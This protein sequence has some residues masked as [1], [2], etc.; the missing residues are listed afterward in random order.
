MDDQIVQGLNATLTEVMN[1]FR[2][3]F[4]GP[5]MNMPEEHVTL[6]HRADFDA[7]LVTVMGHTYGLRLVFEEEKG[8]GEHPHIAVEVSVNV[9]DD[10]FSLPRFANKMT[11]TYDPT[12]LGRTIENFMTPDD[13]V[14]IRKHGESPFA[15]FFSFQL[16]RDLQ[17]VQKEKTRASTVTGRFVD[18]ILKLR[19][20][21]KTKEIKLLA[22]DRDLSLTIVYLLCLRPFAAAYHES[23]TI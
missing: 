4:V 13:L 10:E 2:D 11:E 21:I 6:R 23:L 15:S 19:Y 18:T 14:H 1:R 8:K 17:L 22:R 7:P 9:Y 16:D 5:G 12:R 20:W 3:F